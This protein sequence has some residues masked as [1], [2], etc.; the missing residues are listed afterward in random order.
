MNKNSPE[1]KRAVQRTK[2][3]INS[4]NIVNLLEQEN[5]TVSKQEAMDIKGIAMLSILTDMKN[6]SEA[7]GDS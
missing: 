3:Y 4:L 5:L 2:D 7:N 6:T 1:Y